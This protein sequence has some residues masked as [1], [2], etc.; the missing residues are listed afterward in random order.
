MGILALSGNDYSA[1]FLICVLMNCAGEVF[2]IQMND[3]EWGE[4]THYEM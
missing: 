4:H 2:F 3:T 1:A